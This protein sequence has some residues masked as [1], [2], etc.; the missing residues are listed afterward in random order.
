[1]KIAILHAELPENAGR[2]ELDVLDQVEL[3]KKVLSDLGIESVTIPIS[4]NFNKAVSDLQAAA[5]DCVF[6]LVE[7]LN[8]IGRFIY[9]VPTLLDHL[10]IPYTGCSTEAIF[11]TTNKVLTKE[12]LVADGL[13]TPEW[14]DGQDVIGN[15]LRI[16]LPC[17]IKPVWEDASV[18]LDDHAIV[19]DP[20][21]L[22]EVLEKHLN[23]YGN[24]FVE[25]YIP[26]RE[27]NLSLVAS[28]QGNA[29]LLPPAEIVFKDFPAGKPRIVGYRAKWD[30]DS[31]EYNNTVRSFDFDM[32]DET[33][34]K[35][36]A[37]LAMQ[38]WQSFNLKGFARV[39]FRIDEQGNPWILEVNAN[40]C[41]APDSGFIAAAER[42]GLNTVMV[43]ERIIADAG[44][45]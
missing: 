16:A 15:G 7:S 35:R 41:I 45:L 12:R 19:H 37:G 9:M 11:L 6:N 27:F 40:P 2:D 44:I 34:L 22:Q 8:G 26:G 30:S 25:S 29:Q 42:A 23:L 13:P 43:I 31:F 4:L 20:H 24:C 28:K 3:V 21:I 17:I 39:D 1:M 36:L 5:V 18:G 10:R 14:Q 38:C 32:N 33:V